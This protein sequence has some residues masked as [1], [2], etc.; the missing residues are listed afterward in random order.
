MPILKTPGVYYNE[1]VE[2]E[3]IGEGSKIPVFIG[4]TGNT[5][6]DGKYLVDGTQINKY[7]RWKEI[8]KTPANGGVGVY[9]E[10][11]TNE[12][13][14]ALKEFFEESDIETTEDIG[15]PYL[16]VIDVG[17]GTD[18]NAWLNAFTTAK[19][20]RDSTL[21]AVI[22]F[23][24]VTGGKSEID[25]MNAFG[26][27]IKTETAGLNL[28]GGLVRLPTNEVTGEDGKL[29][30]VDY[31]NDT[32]NVRLD[33]VG[34][35]EKHKFGKTVARFCCTPFY[36][37]PG[38]FAYRS[39]KPGEFIERTEEE[40]KLLQDAGI[41][42]N[43][44]EKI[45]DATYP[46]INLG[47]VSTFAENPRPADSLF[48]ARFISDELLKEI[49]KVLYPQVKNNESA[50]NFVYLQSQINK[51]IDDF[52]NEGYVIKYNSAKGTG[53][54]LTLRESDYNPYDMIVEG[55]IQP[56][57][58]TIAIMVQATIN[59]ST[60]RVVEGTVYA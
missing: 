4:V 48:H 23:E 25:L 31:T 7:S 47:V 3:L 21:E 43:R 44:D 45:G 14:I 2:Y 58:S 42:F 22:G 50:S 37:E 13:L 11:T 39:V 51:V 19:I 41:I 10:T 16:Y 20:K 30:L 49:F 9:S 53:T 32:N 54:R 26:A 35:C 59:V 55:P 27:S 29:G 46:K 38:F 5:K 1:D 28:R 36:H 12:L 24:K 17:T 40:E 33:R 56:V 57:N 15:V 6:I 18:A 52:I 60:L 34:L 8:N